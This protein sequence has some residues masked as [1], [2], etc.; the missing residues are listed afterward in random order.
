MDR[1]ESDV[2]IDDRQGRGMEAATGDLFLD[3]C[4][5]TTF[6]L[7]EIKALTGQNKQ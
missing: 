4:V 3:W 2:K 5:N 7:P 6:S 1:A